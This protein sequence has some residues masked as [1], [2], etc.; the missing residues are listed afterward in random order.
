MGITT[1][2]ILQQ[3]LTKEIPARSRLYSL[4]L[5]VIGTSFIECPT[6]YVNR[7]GW[8]Y[9]VSP[10]TLVTQLLASN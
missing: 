5:L 7:L 6:S 3:M 1:V 8:S 10:R 2:R 9:C 4:V